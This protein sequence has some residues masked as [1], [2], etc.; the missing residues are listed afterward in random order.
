MPRRLKSKQSSSPPTR[1]SLPSWVPWLGLLVS[2]FVFVWHASRFWGYTID[3][4]YISYRYALNWVHG[5]GPVYNVGERVEG[6]TNFL[7]TALLAAFMRLGAEP[8]LTSKILGLLSGLGSIILLFALGQR[9]RPRSLFSAI[10]PLLIALHWVFAVTAVNGLETSL[11]AFFMVGALWSFVR[12]EQQGSDPTGSTLFA[13]GA[14]LTRPDGLLVFLA[15]VPLRAVSL[16][17]KYARRERRLRALACWIGF[18]VMFGV[19]QGWRIWFYRSLFPNTLVAKGGGSLQHLTSGWSDLVNFLALTGYWGLL[20]AVLPI[21]V[22]QARQWYLPALLLII[23]RF[24]FQVWS[25]GPWM[26]EHRFMAPIL[27]V[28]YL[29]VVE[30]WALI[31]TTRPGITTTRRAMR[32]VAVLGCLGWIVYQAQIVSWR[33][34]MPILEVRVRGLNS[35]HIRLGRWLAHH[36]RPGAVLSCQDAGALPYYSG[37]T[38]VDQLGLNDRHIAHIPRPFYYKVDADYLLRLRPDYLVLLSRTPRSQGFT[39][40]TE[41]DRILYNNPRFQRLYSQWDSIYRY[42]DDYYLWVFRPLREQ[43][44]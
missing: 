3:D 23:T 18:L 14:A 32:A 27:P 37:L 22:R 17:Y 28:I 7:W 30:G 34:A 25:G 12:E 16:M 38:T 24:A 6:Y 9:I 40:R 15:L 33:G 44:L 41:V 29:C 26:G 36:A 1:A 31:W 20:P 35:A 4:A 21:A 39:G 5:H 8:V 10:A 13:L 43:R 42:D 19:Y 2:A 11:L